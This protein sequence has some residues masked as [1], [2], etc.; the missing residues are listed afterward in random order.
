MAR[1][2]FSDQITKTDAFSEMPQGSQLLYFFLGMEADS[3]GFV[4]NPRAILRL[5]RI[6]EDDYKILIA[7]NFVIPF[8]SGVCVVKHWRINNQIR[9]DRYTET[10]YLTE[11]STLFIKDNGSYTLD[12]N[13][14]RPVP[15]GHFIVNED[16]GEIETPHLGNRLATIGQPSI[17]EVSKEKN[18]DNTFELFWKEYPKKELKKRATEIWARKKFGKDLPQILEFIKKAKNTDR[19]KK[20]YI[21]QP[22][23]F[24]NGECWNDDLSGYNDKG[25]SGG[26][27]SFRRDETDAE[28]VL[29][30]QREDKQAEHERIVAER[31]N[32]DLKKFNED[33]KKIGKIDL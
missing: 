28:K 5:R 33:M 3:D 10:K 30:L 27:K 26:G 2:M 15:R 11:K 12:H 14:G 4:P 18:K 1:R 19:W 24:L 9:K 13:Q 25:F 16:K 20:G 31:D 8:D 32:E 23:A 7:K 21:K 17:G 22:P 6:S 29:R